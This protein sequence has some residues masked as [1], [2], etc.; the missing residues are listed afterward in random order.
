M[1]ARRK[2]SRKIPARSAKSA[3]RSKIITSA[4]GILVVIVALVVVVWAYAGHPATPKT[5][6]ATTSTPMAPIITSQRAASGPQISVQQ[7]MSELSSSKSQ[8][9]FTADYAGTIYSSISTQPT[10]MTGN[11]LSQF[12]RYNGSARSSTSVSSAQA[13]T[14]NSSAYYFKNGTSYACYTNSSSNPICQKANTTFNLSTFGISSFLGALPANYSNSISAVN[15]SYRGFKCTELSAK[16]YNSFNNSGVILNTTE[17]VSGCIQ[18]VYKIPLV[19]NISSQTTA[20]GVYFNGT[21]RNRITPESQTVMVNLHMVN[22][23][24]SSTASAVENLPANALVIGQ[25]G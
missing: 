14:F 19:L 11:L 21:V 12:E 6:Y 24:N 17:Y 7:L 18:L 22:I 9:Q 16:I 5:S 10:A 23:T 13:G 3:D 1:P 25:A 4:V 20:Q 15:S 2:S 8:N